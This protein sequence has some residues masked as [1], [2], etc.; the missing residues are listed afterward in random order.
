MAARSYPEYPT[1]REPILNL[2]LLRTYI[3][4][5]LYLSPYRYCHSYRSWQRFLY[6]IS[7]SLISSFRLYHIVEGW[8]DGQRDVNTITESMW[9]RGRTIILHCLFIGRVYMN[10]MLINKPLEG[11]TLSVRQLYAMDMRVVFNY[12]CICYYKLVKNIIVA[13]CV[14]GNAL[15]TFPWSEHHE[16]IFILYANG[17][18]SNQCLYTGTF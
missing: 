15:C 6:C 16:N 4:L 5:I 14:D 1:K 7:L 3:V 12:T 18:G 13:Y 2:P 10:G 9:L 11:A 8:I 17:K